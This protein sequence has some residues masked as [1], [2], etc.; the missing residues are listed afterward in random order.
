MA[1]DSKGK[2]KVVE[3]PNKIEAEASNR[4]QEDDVSAESASSDYSLSDSEV[5]VM[6]SAFHSTLLY[7]EK[8]MPIHV[9]IFL[10]FNV[11]EVWTCSFSYDLWGF[12]LCTGYC[13]WCIIAEFTLH[14]LF[15]NGCILLF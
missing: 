2:E 10:I 14:W 12:Q 8:K 4:A 5:E 1:K 3:S 6:L 15:T 11:G 13:V 7:F 9:M